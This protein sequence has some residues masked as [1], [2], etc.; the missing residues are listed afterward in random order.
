MKDSTQPAPGRRRWLFRVGRWA[1]VL[2]IFNVV[3]GVCF[4]PKSDNGAHRNYSQPAWAYAAAWKAQYSDEFVRSWA[5]EY[6]P[7]VGWRR[8][9]FHGDYINTAGGIRRSYQGKDATRPD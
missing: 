1:I 8:R 5:F 9:D 7:F 3:A 2:I 4:R 6:E